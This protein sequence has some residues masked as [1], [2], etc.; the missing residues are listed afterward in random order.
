M[1]QLEQVG[2]KAT[3]FCL[4]ENL[5]KNTSIAS[6]LKD[7]GHMVANHTNTHA[8]GWYTPNWNYQEDIR[9]C[10]GEL[11]KLGIHNQ[12]F[13]PPY[14]RI[15]KSQINS[16][17]NRRIVMWSHLSWDFDARLDLSLITI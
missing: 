6:R 10:D 17:K 7:A 8:D 11:M 5:K 16:L 2:G 1:Q 13:R 9:A 3:F 4:G 14:G 12:L 15:R